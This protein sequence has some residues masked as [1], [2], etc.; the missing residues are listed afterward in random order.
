MP[1]PPGLGQ[2]EMRALSKAGLG[3]VGPAPALGEVG[4]GLAG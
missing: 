2:P 4:L 1:A 3:K